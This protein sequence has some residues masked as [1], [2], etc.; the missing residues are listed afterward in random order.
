MRWS[1][2][3]LAKTTG[4]SRMTGRDLPRNALE[5]ILRDLHEPWLILTQLLDLIAWHVLTSLIGALPAYSYLPKFP[6]CRVT[7]APLFNVSQVQKLVTAAVNILRTISESPHPD[8]SE[9][10]ISPAIISKQRSPTYAA[11]IIVRFG[12]IF[13]CPR[14]LRAPIRIVQCR[15]L[16][17]H[18][19][20]TRITLTG[21]FDW[22]LRGRPVTDPCNLIH[23]PDSHIRLR[24]NGAPS[25]P[26]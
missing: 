20:V 25:S 23:R 5:E 14:F 11:M 10:R 18:A 8:F 6:S 17:S 9:R 22:N 19:A 26:G 16:D 15:L 3:G 12:I 24:L 7:S 1:T 2:R 13:C 4:L 21:D